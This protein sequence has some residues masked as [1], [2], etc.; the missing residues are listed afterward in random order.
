MEP[1]LPVLVY[2]HAL[3]RPRKSSSRPPQH[4]SCTPRRGTR[5]TRRT[6]PPSPLWRFPR[7]PLSNTHHSYKRSTDGADAPTA[8]HGIATCAGVSGGRNYDDRRIKKGFSHAGPLVRAPNI[9]LLVQLEERKVHPPDF[10]GVHVCWLGRLGLVL[11][12][13][14]CFC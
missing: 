2:Q 4:R 6:D 11:S 9:V 10:T 1:E 14:A 3:T 8:E 5:R 7:T 12:L 13:P